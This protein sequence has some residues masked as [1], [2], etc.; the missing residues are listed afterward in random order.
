M[1]FVAEQDGMVQ[2]VAERARATRWWGI[3]LPALPRASARVERIAVAALAAVA[4]GVVF[5][6][7]VWT[8]H[9]RLAEG[10]V[11]DAST[12][13]TDSSLLGVVGVTSLAAACAGLVVVGLVRRRGDLAIVAVG[14]VA[15]STGVGQLLKHLVL[16]RPTLLAEQG[17]SFPSGHMIAFAGVAAGLLV[18]LPAALRLVAAPVASV[19]LSLVAVR[20]VHDGWHRPSDVVGSLLLVV[21]L[22]AVGTLW[23]PPAPPMRRA[24]H[25]IVELA[26]VGGAIVAGLVAGIAAML[27]SGDATGQRLLLAASAGLVAA[28]LVAVATLS[29]L[30]RRPRAVDPGARHLR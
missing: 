2:V 30:L 17:N 3:P 1:V 21:C 27:A 7:A 6:V 4:F 10:A 9:G 15:A 14:I 20:L 11:L 24:P 25:R 19:V 26:L 13:A 29:W 5:A 28:V 23:R 22:T 12:F 18:V 16:S 8:E